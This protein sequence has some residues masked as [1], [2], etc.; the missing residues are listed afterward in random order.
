MGTLRL[1]VIVATLLALAPAWAGRAASGG[2]VTD[3]GVSLV[4]PATHW[5]AGLA[6]GL[7]DFRGT[8]PSPTADVL[9]RLA[10]WYRVEGLDS[11]E[12]R[13]PPPSIELYTDQATFLWT[14]LDGRNLDLDIVIRP[15]DSEAPSGWLSIIATVRN[16]G[17]Q[18]RRV[19]L[20][21]YL[22]VDGGGT[23]GD[24][25]GELRGS[26]QLA[27]HDS[28]S[29]PPVRV[30][31]RAGQ[32]WS[33]RGVNASDNLLDQLD[34]NLPTTLDG[35]GLPQNLPTNLAAAL[36]GVVNAQ[37]GGPA[38]IA[39]WISL[40]N[41]APVDVAKGDWDGNG[42]PDLVFQYPAT[43]QEYTWFMQRK[44]RWMMAVRGTGGRQMRGVDRFDAA[45]SS[46]QRLDQDAAG[47]V[48]IDAEPLLGAPVLAPNW[49]IAATGD[50]SGDGLGDI[51]WRNTTS[52]KLV[53]WTVSGF[54]K[55]GN[56]IPSPD[57]AVDANWEVVG[58]ADFT[59]DGA[60]DL[61]WYN[62]VS[63]NLV[64][65]AM[66]SAVVR[67]NGFFTSPASAGGAN[68]RPVAVGDFGRGG[69]PAGT[70]DIVW[71]NSTSGR[72]VVWYLDFAGQRTSGVFT[73]P[74]LPTDPLNAVV[75]GPR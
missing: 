36:Q 54:T 67:V 37:P 61:L 1:P 34:D 28:P 6:Y 29:A 33:V 44:A 48:Y 75:T 14:N 26:T 63:G 71:R 5:D 39:L 60:R 68:W 46:S 22:D 51:L 70:P 59:G 69:G 24:D 18:A 10:F 40:S 13:L 32:S 42:T 12:L 21:C 52:Q 7:I 20:F 9:T 23:P 62:G 56:I 66:N 27:L 31:L 38:P 19:F 41:R 65:W 58:A 73:S 11:H 8:E 57:Q 49:Q 55:I 53:I 2:T 74:D 45:R 25:V 15:G 50:F 30:L 64:I 47:Q 72:L 17:T 3:G 16:T 4:V 35:S 43:N